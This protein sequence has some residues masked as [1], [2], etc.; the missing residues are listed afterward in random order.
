MSFSSLLNL[1]WFWPT[2]G[3]PHTSVGKESTCKAGEPS[4]IPGLGRSPGEGKGYPLQYSGLEKSTD[5]QRVGNDWS[6][7]TFTLTNGMNMTLLSSKARPW[8]TLYFPFLPYWKASAI[9]TS[10]VSFPENKTPHGGRCPAIPAKIPDMWVNS[11]TWSRDD[12]SR[13][14]PTQIANLWNHEQIN[15]YCF[16][17]WG[18]LWDSNW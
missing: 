18:R 9:W 13:L 3:F 15:A 14:S 2:E 4:S 5:L 1:G 10:S 8:K 7:F 16:H 11:T 6:T 17:V 12:L